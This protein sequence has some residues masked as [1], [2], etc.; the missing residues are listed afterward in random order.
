MQAGDY[1]TIT[2]AAGEG[3]KVYLPA[4]DTTENVTL[5]IGADGST[6]TDI[7]LTSV[8]CA[9]SSGGALRVNFQPS[10]QTP[11]YGYY[12]DYGAGQEGHWGSAGAQGYGW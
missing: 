5:Y 4:L 7:G 6:Y 9:A 3:M 10:A 2:N 11:P 8:A 1:L 12:R